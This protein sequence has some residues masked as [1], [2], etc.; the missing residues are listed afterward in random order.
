MYVFP[1]NSSI[2]CLE[3]AFRAL[4]SFF[5][6]LSFSTH[7]LYPLHIRL[8]NLAIESEISNPTT[9]VLE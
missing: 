1:R 7:S 9:Q 3:P 5:S 2:S 6:K 8:L 4:L